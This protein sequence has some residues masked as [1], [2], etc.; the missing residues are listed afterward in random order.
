[1]ETAERYLASGPSENEPV[2]CCSGTTNSV[3]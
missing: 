1:V 2:P 3:N